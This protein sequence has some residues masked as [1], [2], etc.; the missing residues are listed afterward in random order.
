MQSTTVANLP[1]EVVAIIFNNLDNVRFILPCILACRKFYLTYLQ[2]P[3]IKREVLANHIT[4]SLLP[5]AVAV[6]VASHLPK[7]LSAVSIDEVLGGIYG[8]Q[9]QLNARLSL[10]EM[11]FDDLLYM[12]RMHDII[13]G[14]V[15]EF[16]GS[17]WSILSPHDTNLSVSE[18][19]RF[20]RAFYRFEILCSL[21][22]TESPVF[23]D[24]EASKAKAQFFSKHPSWE[25]EQIGCVHDFLE[26]KMSEGQWPLDHE[27]DCF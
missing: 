22:S 8:S 16:A 6:R 25:N 23:T 24:L 14:L 9:A 15:M 13:H 4:K 21:F 12:A 2:Y 7:P 18:Y 19:S 11:P 27:S 26:R 1:C 17:A 20:C 5:Y 3:S 10:D